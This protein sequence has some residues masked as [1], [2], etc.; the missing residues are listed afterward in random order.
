MIQTPFLELE[1]VEEFTLLQVV[2]IFL[3]LNQS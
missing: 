2:W 1:G 3:V